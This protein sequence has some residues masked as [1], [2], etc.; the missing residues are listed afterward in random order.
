MTS[1]LPEIAAALLDPGIYPD[2]TQ[3]IELMQT[4]MS[5]IFLTGRYVY[6]VKKAV[7][8]GYLDYTTLEKRL[9][10]CKQELELN[11]RL[12]PEAYLD[13]IPI[14]RSRHGINLSGEG[15]VIDYAVKML[16]LPQDRMMNVLLERNQVS[17]EMA[18]QVAQKLVEFHSRAA[19]GP[20]IGVFGKTK[21]VKVNTDENFT[22]TEKYISRT[23]TAGQHRRIKKYTD[24]LLQDKADVFNDRAGSGKVRDCH[25]DLHAQHICFQDGICIYDCIEFNDRF[26]YCDV[27]SEIA[28]LA[29]DLDHFA[30][31]DL[32]RSF[33][34]S[35]MEISGDRQ[36]RELLKFYKCYRAYVR[37]K[38]GCFKLD[39]PYIP[40]E[41]RK[42]TLESARSYFEL[43][44]SYSRSRPL[45][46]ITVGL[47]G[48]G[49]STLTQAIARRLGLTVISSDIVR[50]QLAGVPPTERHFE[51][52]ESGIY[53][54]D[55]SRRTYD[56][57]FSGARDILK[58]GDSVI[59]DA[60]FLK[61]EDR[62]QA[63]QLTTET[64]ADFVILECV[65]DE[66][67]TRQ[68]LEG[69]LKKGSSVSDG[70]WEIY[71]PQKQKFEPVA[72]EET[73]RH[74]V[75]DSARPLF[76]QISHIIEKIFGG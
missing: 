69:R 74:Y 47:V 5:F 8:L 57:L 53:S 11:R 22:Q 9:F 26:R 45:L 25:G 44:E 27:A 3:K 51:G 58:Q 60:T 29:M 33:T 67:N 36:I 40:D 76:D 38:V 15:E 32:A 4:Q 59:L 12:C 55:F 46:F 23:I 31:A 28:F 75:V 49:K 54:A 41:E 1:E 62:R 61:A 16:Y 37:G 30:R 13:V 42:L 52:M 68:R 50:K 56:R 64:G 10:F 24:E 2:K 6:K 66:E 20:D 65:L 7:D 19:T 35:Y 70:R 71:G 21:A 63:R 43:A 39:D 17:P 72:G 34:T 48:S 73:G 18:R 14:S